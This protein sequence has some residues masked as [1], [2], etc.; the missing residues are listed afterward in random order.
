MVL[1]LSLDDFGDGLSISCSKYI[2][3]NSICWRKP[4]HTHVGCPGASPWALKW[5]MILLR[6][7]CNAAV[8]WLWICPSCASRLM[9]LRSPDPWT[10]SWVAVAPKECMTCCIEV[11]K[12]W[13]WEVPPLTNVSS[14]YGRCQWGICK[15]LKPV[16]TTFSSFKYLTLSAWSWSRWLSL[17]LCSRKR[18][19][20][21]VSYI[22]GVSDW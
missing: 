5:S 2:R 16:R 17:S 1:S 4:S 3:S 8:F 14:H 13:I 15:F 6:E 18:A 19:S 12:T 22:E 11:D 10:S 21:S 20:A 7:A 9:S